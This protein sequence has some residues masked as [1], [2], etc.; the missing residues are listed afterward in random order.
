MPD[1][2]YQTKHQH[3]FQ[4]SIA[5][6]L[7]LLRA[8]WQNPL[9]EHTQPVALVEVWPQQFWQG[10]D[11]LPVGNRQKHLFFYPVT[12]SQHAFLMATGADTEITLSR[13][14]LTGSVDLRV[15]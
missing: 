8:C 2:F 13:H 14:A 11:I 15:L 7:L 4:R 1:L 9:S 12:I 6:L 10:K 5:A 3:F